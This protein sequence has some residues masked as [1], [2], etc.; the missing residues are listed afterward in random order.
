M[1]NLKHFNFRLKY[2]INMTVKNRLVCF[3]ILEKNGDLTKN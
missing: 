2:S 1:L 3:D